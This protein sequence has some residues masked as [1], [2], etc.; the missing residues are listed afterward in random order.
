MKA[1]RLPIVCSIEL[2]MVSERR[3]KRNNQTPGQEEPERQRGRY[4]DS[5]D[6]SD[7]FDDDEAPRA[8]AIRVV[9]TEKYNSDDSDDDYD[10]ENDYEEE[11]QRKK[12][13]A[14]DIVTSMKRGLRARWYDCYK[15]IWTDK[16]A[17]LY[18][19]DI[20]RKKYV[21][22]P[23]EDKN[24]KEEIFI[25][26]NQNKMFTAMAQLRKNSQT[27]AFLKYRSKYKLIA[28]WSIL[29]RLSY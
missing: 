4:D 26:L 9:D 3:R 7:G 20:L 23:T 8:E 28:V 18:L 14:N 10:T 12:N 5:D 24:T 22:I 25:Q 27:L 2:D 13:H 11:K 6:R 17:N 29:Q 15:F 1:N 19:S 16:D 21:N